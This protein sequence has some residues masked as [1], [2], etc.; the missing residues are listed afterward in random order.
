MPFFAVS[1]AD[2]RHTLLCKN[3][4]TELLSHTFVCQ[5]CHI[6]LP[7][8]SFRFQGMSRAIRTG[9]PYAPLSQ[10][11]SDAGR[12]TM[13]G[14]PRTP[15]DLLD[16]LAAIVTELESL[17]AVYAATGDRMSEYLL[18]MVIQECLD[19]IWRLSNTDDAAQL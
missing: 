10:L 17:Y 11:R 5:L 2:S 12:L 3:M 7:H 14:E 4:V 1:L 18:D 16:S 13:P 19:A 6:P 9:D 15:A 8:A